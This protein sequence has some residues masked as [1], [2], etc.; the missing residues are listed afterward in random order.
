MDRDARRI[1]IAFPNVSLPHGLCGGSKTPKAAILYLTIYGREII[2]LFTSDYRGEDQRWPLNML[3]RNTFWSL[4]AFNRIS[5]RFYCES[6]ADAHTILFIHLGL[7]MC[8]RVCAY[9]TAVAGVVPW[10]KCRPAVY[11]SEFAG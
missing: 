2:I 5:R 8:V 4:I 7:C 9:A 3:A 11:N 10:L 1:V 6:A